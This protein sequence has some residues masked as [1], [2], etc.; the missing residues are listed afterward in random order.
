METNPEYVG[1][2]G[3][4]EVEQIAKIKRNGRV[5]VLLKN[6]SRRPLHVPKDAECATITPIKHYFP[7][8]SYQPSFKG[9]TINEIRPKDT[10]Q[11]LSISELSDFAKVKCICDLSA[12]IHIMD[13]S[14]YTC[15]GSEQI[16]AEEEDIRGPY[17]KPVTMRRM[18]KPGFTIGIVSERGQKFKIK[19]NKETLTA[20]I[21]HAEES[22]GLTS[23]EVYIIAPSIMKFTPAVVFCVREALKELDL[24]PHFRYIDNNI[25]RED[26]QKC[27]LNRLGAQL[28][29]S[30][31]TRIP[32]IHL[33]IPNGPNNIPVDYFPDRTTQREEGYVTLPA[34]YLC[35]QR[36]NRNSFLFTLH[37][38]DVWLNRAKLGH[39]LMASLAAIK[40]IFPRTKLHVLTSEP[41]YQG[42]LTEDITYA[43]KRALGRSDYIDEDQL[44]GELNPIIRKDAGVPDK[45]VY[46]NTITKCACLLC[47][48]G[49]Y[50]PGETLTIGLK[51]MQIQPEF[52]RPKNQKS[53]KPVTS[54]STLSAS[55]TTSS[56]EPPT[57]GET[58]VAEVSVHP[59][60]PEPVI[61]KDGQDPEVEKEMERL[62]DPDE[63]ETLGIPQAAWRKDN[64]YDDPMDGVDLTN[65]YEEFI[66]VIKEIVGEYADTLISY[67][68]NDHS[69]IRGSTLKLRLKD[70]SPLFLKPYP[71][72]PALIECMLALIEDMIKKTI[73]GKVDN[74][75]VSS[76]TFLVPHNSAEKAK[77]LEY[78]RRIADGEEIPPL[79]DEQLKDAPVGTCRANNVRFRPVVDFTQLNRRLIPEPGDYLVQATSLS[80]SGLSRS[81]VITVI[82]I[83]GAFLSLAV[84]P[85][86]RKWMGLSYK[87]PH[88]Y[89]FLF[90]GLGLSIIPAVFSRIILGALRPEVRKYAQ[91]HLD[92]VAIGTN[93]EIHERIVRMLFEDLRKVGLLVEAGKMQL[94]CKEIEYLGYTISGTHQ[95]IQ[96]T[97]YKTEVR[98]PNSKAELASYLGVMS[99]FSAFLPGFSAL[100][101]LLHPLLRAQAKFSPSPLQI[102]AMEE[103]RKLFL[104]APTLCIY[105]FTLP[106]HFSIDSS[107]VGSGAVIY[108]LDKDEF[109]LLAF[110]GS[111]YSATQIRNNSS[112]ELELLAVI[113]T[114]ASHRHIVTL[115]NVI[116]V[117]TD[118][119][120]LVALRALSGCSSNS[121]LSRWYSKLES[122]APALTLQWSSSKD[123]CI[124]AADFFSRLSEKHVRF[125]NRK[126]VSLGA[127]DK[128][129]ENLMELF[130]GWDIDGKV[131]TI[132]DV[133]EMADVLGESPQFTKI[134]EMAKVTGY[135]IHDQTHSDDQHDI[136]EE[137][138]ELATVDIVPIKGRQ[139]YTAGSTGID[140]A[141]LKVNPADVGSKPTINKMGGIAP[142]TYER[143]VKEQTEDPRIKD[144]IRK[145]T[146]SKGHAKLKSRYHMYGGLLYRSSSQPNKESKQVLSPQLTIEVLAIIHL[147]HGHIGAKA[148]IR[149]FNKSYA[150]MNVDKYARVIAQGCLA[151][152]AVRPP[153]S[154]DTNPG[155]IP[156][157]LGYLSIWHLD[158]ITMQAVMVKGR[159]Y[160][161]Y[162]NIMDQ[163]THLSMGRPVTS[164]RGEETLTILRETIGIAGKPDRISMDSGPGLGG[165]TDVIEFCQQWGIEL[166]LNIP[167]HVHSHSYIESQNRVAKASLLVHQKAYQQPWPLV[168]WIHNSTYNH[169]PRP[170]EIFEGD[171]GLYQTIQTSPQILAF[172]NNDGQL[173]PLNRGR[174]GRNTNK[175]QEQ[176][177]KGIL[178]RA[179]EI[180]RERNASD[181]RR[182]EN[183]G[184]GDLVMMKNSN[185]T[186]ARTRQW[187]LPALF[188]VVRRNHR[189]VT[190]KP[191]LGGTHTDGVK[192]MHV[193][194]I[195]PYITL[196][197]LNI[198]PKT[199]LERFGPVVRPEVLP[200]HLNT[201]VRK[202]KQGEPVKILTREEE[203]QIAENTTISDQSGSSKELPPALP[204]RNTI[205]D[206]Q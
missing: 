145:C 138:L 52:L 136:M 150:G 6:V 190:I 158:H 134:L 162:L 36:L 156:L 26:C 54:L 20:L 200:Q 183:Y 85:D 128:L 12:T 59:G 155:K 58:E 102:R 23:N 1:P 164:L 124:Q 142:L 2:Y 122:M 121:K 48:S 118:C 92:D 95:R 186:T 17:T 132:K 199:L 123:P 171:T 27:Y 120:V 172:G 189:L 28:D 191:Y 65:S 86:S 4:L 40:P 56:V 154:R 82:D 72:S 106:V 62:E 143:L 29:R 188:E 89:A 41:M 175:I 63:D 46:V 76:A 160:R 202:T 135:D 68:K 167:N 105:D 10:P 139:Y 100:A 104:E 19:E 107:A 71:L 179:L 18:G 197:D 34:G 144:L 99:Y 166:K 80:I 115:G 184:V 43:V 198:L 97:R 93:K 64:N 13:A 137:E 74:L 181:N 112:L 151:C 24:N 83:R 5:P 31:T 37:H 35:Y 42:N 187:A 195:K 39:A 130:Q 147:Y 133:Q 180:N 177:R 163:A 176:V 149:L 178:E 84:H 44:P 94:F 9:C 73:I 47:R 204:L 125:S 126:V 206:G 78:N 196:A 69:V 194:D 45:S 21:K 159:T 201:A 88:L 75:M 168:S 49:K 111:K 110:H 66:P 129:H 87:G 192:D 30:E 91:V 152:G 60:P 32:N 22:D 148:L 81:E 61:Y 70:E 25:R 90:A 141:A 67:S 55:V 153:T 203:N 170:Y 161:Y 14:G 8:E 185:R 182:T 108:Q 174:D 38:P 33:F 3:G 127:K 57:V 51:K 157:S 109:R 7:T 131:L 50:Q 114:I 79:T 173:V 96:E 53:I 116:I 98:I 119:R 140:I 103:L 11:A 15:L 205:R 169:L 113:K 16:L 146:K 165:S 193:S 101:S 117:H 77:L